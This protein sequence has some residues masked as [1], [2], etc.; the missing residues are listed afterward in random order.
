[1]KRVSDLAVRLRPF[2]EADLDLLTRFAVDRS[3]SEPFSWFGFRRPEHFR[4]R[5]EEDG[6]LD[7]DPRFLAVALADG[8]AIG[9]VTWRENDRPGPGVWEIGALVVPELRGRGAGTEAQRLLVEH[10]FATTTAHR[11]WAGTEAGNLREQRSLERCG[12]QR[13]GLLRGAY[14]RDGRWRD[15][16]IYGILREDVV[17]TEGPSE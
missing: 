8:T 7:A 3:L 2:Q 10:L 1:M 16:L 5:W 12:F 14:F 15:S 11:I 9:W 13:E 6:F 4:R 17:T